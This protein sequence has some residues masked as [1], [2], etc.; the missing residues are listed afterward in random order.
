MKRLYVL[1]DGECGFCVRCRL[2]LEKQPQYVRLVFIAKRS[3]E[4]ER[5]FGQLYGRIAA[6]ELVAIGD[7]GAVYRG[8]SAF[9]ICL[10]A[11]RDY[12][13]WA[14]RLSRPLLRPLARQLFEALS[15]NRQVFSRWFGAA[16]DDALMG[17]LSRRPVMRCAVNGR[18]ATDGGPKP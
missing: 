14:Q 2:W 10:W 7:N 18:G 11:L 16:T 5:R 8:P 4:A 12:R 3:R 9:L 13:H 1:F 6:D 17:W 15:R